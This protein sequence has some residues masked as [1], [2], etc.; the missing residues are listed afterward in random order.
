MKTKN[1]F[2]TL[3][4]LVAA[5]AITFSA[6]KKNTDGPGDDLKLGNDNAKVQSDIDEGGNAGS[7]AFSFT[8][9]ALRLS[10]PGGANQVQAMIQICGASIDTSMLTSQKQI[11]IT[12]DGNTP[13]GGK[14]RGG[15]IRAKL[16]AGAKW[17]D[18]G[19]V[20]LV[21]FT[22]YKV[23]HIATATEFTYNGTKTYINLTGGLIRT[24]GQNPQVTHKVRGSM[25]VTFDDG[26]QRTWWIARKNTYDANG[27]NT[28]LIVEGDTTISNNVCTVGGINRLG[29]NFLLQAPSA[30]VLLEGCGWDRPVNGV[31]V[32]TYNNRTVSLTFGVD[33]QGSPAGGSCAYGY[34]IEWTRLNGDIGSAVIAY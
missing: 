3:T 32:H 25:Q 4:T 23:E 29:N 24:L 5:F 21:T 26:T 20:L 2:L 33:A 19:A 14:I 9:L 27:G 18:I 11:T 30:L 1:I 7:E 17:S 6:C 13:C 10:E 12:F 15:T 34:K 16:V 28:R 22:N 31:R 8:S